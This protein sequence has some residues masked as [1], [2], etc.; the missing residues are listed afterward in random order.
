MK[1]VDSIRRFSLLPHP[2]LALHLSARRDVFLVCSVAS[3]VKEGI[4]MTHSTENA[5]TAASPWLGLSAPRLS[6]VILDAH[7]SSTNLVCDVAIAPIAP[8]RPRPRPKSLL[9]SPVFLL[10][11]PILYPEQHV[12][13]NNALFTRQCDIPVQ[14]ALAVVSCVIRAARVWFVCVATIGPRGRRLR[15]KC[16]VVKTNQSSN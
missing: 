15:E 13:N 3:V 4:N 12:N 16:Y 10:K 8:P 9:P 11:S 6:E 7:V 14:S 5:W 2:P 1:C